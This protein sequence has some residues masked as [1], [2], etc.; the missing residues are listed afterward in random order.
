MRA[1]GCAPVRW[2]A[3]CSRV[4]LGSILTIPFWQNENLRHAKPGTGVDNSIAQ[5]HLIT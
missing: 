2:D 3:T 5:P 1:D 4:A